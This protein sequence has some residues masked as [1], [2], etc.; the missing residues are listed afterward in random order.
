VLQNILNLLP[1]EYVEKLMI[2]RKTK[3][4]KEI[5]YK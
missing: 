4:N 3:N 1:V 2:N 5:K